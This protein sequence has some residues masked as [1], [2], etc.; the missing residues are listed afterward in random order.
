MIVKI[1][2]TLF[3]GILVTTYI[4]M[5]YL[6][7]ISTEIYQNSNQVKINNLNA[8]FKAHTCKTTRN[9][10]LTNF[11]SHHNG[12]ITEKTESFD[13]LQQRPL[14]L[15]LGGLDE[16]GGGVHLGLDAGLD[17]GYGLLGQG[18]VRVPPELDTGHHHLRL[19]LQQDA[20]VAD[21]VQG[22]QHQVHFVLN[23]NFI[24]NY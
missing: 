6:M 8:L 15:L 2:R 4:C 24:R 18:E 10:M 13:L 20:A 16:G 21:L 14:E 9:K 5:T 1:K 23:K 17:L 7:L 11:A 12:S 3:Y 19:R 22:Q